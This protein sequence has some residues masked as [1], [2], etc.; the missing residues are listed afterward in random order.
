M[1]FLMPLRQDLSLFLSQVTSGLPLYKIFTSSS[2]IIPQLCTRYCF[3]FF[4]FFQTKSKTYL[5]YFSITVPA[6]WC[7]HGR[8]REKIYLDP[9][10]LAYGLCI[11][12][13]L[14]KGFLLFFFL[15]FF[16]FQK[17]K[18]KKKALIFFL[19]LHENIFCGYSLEVL[20][21]MLQVLNEVPQRTIFNLITVHTPISARSNNSV[22]FRLQPVYFMSRSL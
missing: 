10:I 7:F 4:F 3:F 15:F 19:F 5:S 12:I 17:K 21:C 16:F 13:T 14:D 2:N 22:V 9:V 20:Q 18:K 11:V 6:T 8:I 1:D